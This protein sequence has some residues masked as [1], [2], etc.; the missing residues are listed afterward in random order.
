MKRLVIIGAS[1]LAREVYSYACELG[2]DVRGFLDSR[3]NILDDYVG[4]PPILGAVEDF[5]FTSEDVCVCAVGDPDRRRHYVQIAQTNGA[6]FTSIIHPTAI[7]ERNAVCGIGSIVQPY[8]VVGSDARV[9]NHVFLGIHSCIGH[10]DRV[11]D[12]VTIS[13]GCQV[14]GW[15]TL[16]SGTFLGIQ[17]TV[18]PHVE[19]GTE[20]TSVFVAAGTVVVKDVKEGLVKGVPAK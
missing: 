4:Y 7:I 15:V 18:I 14:A 19:I 11:D 6:Q 3:R 17:S 16:H 13:P 10:D 20:N 2:M 5:R 1:A 9:G 12:F 8:V